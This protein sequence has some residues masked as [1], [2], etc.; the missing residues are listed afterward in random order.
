MPEPRL[1]APMATALLGRWPTMIA[2]TM[3]ID[4]PADF[5]EHQWRGEVNRWNELFLERFES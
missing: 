2:S 5:A 1:T 4:H 3:P